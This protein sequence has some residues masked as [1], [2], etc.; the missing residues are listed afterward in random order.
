ME[1]IPE[2][3]EALSELE[4]FGDS[5]L[6]GDLAEVAAT[7]KE[8]IPTLV[9]LSLTLVAEQLVLTYVA[10]GLEVAVMDA[11]QYIDG[12]PCVEAVADDEI[13][14]TAVEDLLDEGRWQLFAQATAAAGVRSTLSIP[15][16]EEGIVTG[17]VNLYGGHASSFQG[18][19]SELARLFGGWA[20]GVVSNADLSFSTRLEAV[21][22]PERLKGQAYVDQAV[23][24]LVS[25]RGIE[26]SVAEE[27]LYLA[28]AQAGTS[29]VALA[30]AIVSAFTGEA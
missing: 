1:P 3:D 8:K 11:V 12:G 17:G 23:G 4:R 9:G 19:E 30:R 16:G 25:S 24:L 2:T 28:A 10:T 27:R 18:Q 20:P 13:V 15:F 7:A 6:R 22:S 5:D 26:A 14:G 29:V 21:R